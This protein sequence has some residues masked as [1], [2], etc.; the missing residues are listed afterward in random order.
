MKSALFA[1]SAALMFCACASTGPATAWNKAGVSRVDY[2]TDTGMCTGY[3][4]LKQSGNGANTAGGVS[5]SNSGPM[6][7]HPSRGS[8]QGESGGPPSPAQAATSTSLPASGMYSGTASADYAARAAT[9]QR[10]Q[11]MAARRAQAEA[12][13]SCLAERGYREFA[14]APEHRARL[15]SFKVGSNEYRE[16]LYSLA[17]DPEVASVAK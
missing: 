12:Y 16:Y 15:A 8:Q 3:A 5:G 17:T 2:G 11:Q 10:A 6:T 7:D 9:Q 13:K 1:A 14:L 4:S